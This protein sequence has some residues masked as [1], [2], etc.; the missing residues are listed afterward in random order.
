MVKTLIVD[1]E[2]LICEFIQDM[3]D[4]EKKDMQCLGFATDGLSALEKAKISLPDL[5][6]TDIRMPGLSGIEL[7]RKMKE[8][9]PGC[10]F[11]VISGYQD[12]DYIKQAVDL[13]AVSYIL[14]PIDQNE[15]EITLDR[16]RRTI[17]SQKIQEDYGKKSEENVRL[18]QQLNLQKMQLGIQTLERVLR[19]EEVFVARPDQLNEEFA[20][21]LRAG[22]FNVLVAVADRVEDEAADAE[23]R[24]KALNAV[25]KKLKT[26]L[27]SLCFFTEECEAMGNRALLLNF[28]PSSFKQVLAGIR[29]AAEQQHV[30]LYKMRV[31]FGMSA[32]GTCDLSLLAEL[33]AKGK[34]ACMRRIIK[35]PGGLILSHDDET[36]KYC[37][38]NV[39]RLFGEKWKA[40]FKNSLE[41]KDKDKCAEQIA[42][43]FD[44]LAEVKNMDPKAY[45]DFF[46]TLM[47]HIS[48]ELS[49]DYADELREV[50]Y[51]E[52]VEQAMQ[53]EGSIKG[54]LQRADS[55]LNVVFA[56]CK[57][58]KS[59]SENKFV[60]IAKA[61]VAENYKKKISV[62]DVAAFLYMNPDYFS[63]LFK[64]NQGIGFIEYL[65]EYR[66]TIA[67]K[68]LKQK[69]ASISE[70]AASVGYDDA[71]Y[72]SKTFKK[73][74]GASPAE[75][76][77]LF[78]A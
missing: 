71:K 21:N 30:D 28:D 49:H 43:L 65:T 25:F 14:K 54:L 68:L 70:I 75:Y 9:V 11:I 74:V 23:C 19:G 29:E 41:L 33:Y 34:D 52:L 64:K 7:I 72:F 36:Q 35:K 76:K 77:R 44:K 38:Y 4:W 62:G 37:D 20:W 2:S 63:S 15:L 32:E 31:T 55:I 45:Y 53:T 42:Q 22:M 56:A 12:F 24:Q 5:M 69:D 59:V 40:L 61:F 18:Q 27:K 60:S 67:R 10:Q 58:K 57:N 46:R 3:I 48:H 51:V 8:V 6:I 1:D 47:Q 78:E 50:G 73:V 26:T 13:G 16:V 17:N 66:I 39:H